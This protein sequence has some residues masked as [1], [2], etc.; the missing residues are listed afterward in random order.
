MEV[1][2]LSLEC[3]KRNVGRSR[4]A[5]SWSIV[6]LYD[7]IIIH[8]LN[9]LVKVQLKVIYNMPGRGLDGRFVMALKI[10][11]EIAK[12]SKH[13]SIYGEHM[14]SRWWN[15][16]CQLLKVIVSSLNHI[17]S[18][19]IISYHIISYHIISYHISYHIISYHIISY[20]IISYHISY[21]II[22]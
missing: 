21:H 15:V 2:V 20:H 12:K 10:G 14:S 8:F 17:I 3:P 13:F 7:I 9:G 11:I 19:H 1:P 16:S 5:C 22:S 6:I 4:D 18:Y